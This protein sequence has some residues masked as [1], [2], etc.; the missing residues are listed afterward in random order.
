MRREITTTA[1]GSTTI[2]LPDWD[3][4]YHSKHGAIQEARHVFIHN[5]L[6]LF[7]H[8]SIHILE[9]G[10]GTGLNALMTLIEAPQYGL[11][12]H[13]EGVEAYPIQAEEL[14]AMNFAQSLSVPTAV[15]QDLHLC[16]WNEPHVINPYFTLTKRHL[17]FDQLAGSSVFDLIY[18][19]VFGYRVQP[20]LWSE[21]MFHLMYRLLK[22]GGILVTYAARSIIKRNMTAA[23]FLVVKLPGP[24]GKREMFR[25]HKPL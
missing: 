23:G 22:P 14:Q 16:S 24:P 19:D 1:D 5:G 21:E 4:Q 2:H 15:F 20:E 9:M 13:Y 7:E 25:A 6:A 18:F 10:F 3:E 12:V 17:F 8:Q 11:T